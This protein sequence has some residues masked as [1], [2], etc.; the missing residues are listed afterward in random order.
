[1]RAAVQGEKQLFSMPN[2]TAIMVSFAACFALR[3]STQIG[4]AT[5]NNNTSGHSSASALALAPSVRTLIEETA[6]I[7]DKIGNITRHRNGMCALYAKYIRILLKKTAAE[8]GAVLSRHGMG[9]P[10]ANMAH[11]YSSHAEASSSSRK[12]GAGAGSMSYAR[13]NSTSSKAA[14]S[15]SLGGFAMPQPPSSGMGGYDTTNPGWSSTTDLFPFSSMSGDQII[16]ALN[17][18]GGEFDA[19]G[20]FGSGGVGAGVSSAG[21]SGSGSGFGWDDGASFD[22]MPTWSTWPDFGFQ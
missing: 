6:D 18:A 22:F 10:R 12:A 13:S 4:A 8:T 2:N 15:A 7:L 11:M 9:T 3:L 17:R 19:G 1:M 21:A 16:E 20:V 5:S 14:A